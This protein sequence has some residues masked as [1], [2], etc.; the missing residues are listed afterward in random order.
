VYRI[1]LT[2]FIDAGGVALTDGEPRGQDSEGR[3]RIPLMSL[4]TT[5]PADSMP[6]DMERLLRTQNVKVHLIFKPVGTWTLPARKGSEKLEGVKARFIAVRLTNA[7][8][9]E[10]I[11]LKVSQ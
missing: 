8:T 5:L 4:Y 10:E 6:M 9:G 7:R 11:A 3:P 2:P 1:D